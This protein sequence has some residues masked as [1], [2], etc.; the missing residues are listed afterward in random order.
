MLRERKRGGLRVFVGMI[1][2]AE[3]AVGFLDFPVRGL[4]VEV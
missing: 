3:F 1:L 4:F 2:L